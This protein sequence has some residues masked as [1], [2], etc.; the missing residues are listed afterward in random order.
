MTDTIVFDMGQ[1]L[2]RWTPEKMIAQYNLNEQ[3]MHLLNTELF[4]G[5]EWVMQDRGILSEDQ[6]VA[7][8]RARLPETLHEP[9]KTLVYGWH[10]RYLEPMPGMGALVREL[11]ANG[12]RICLLSN[13]GLALR[14]YFDRIPGSECFDGLMVSAEEK[15]LKPQHEIYETLFRKFGLIPENCM[16]IDDAPANVEGGM[17]VGMPGII[18][19]GDV[20]RLRRELAA[21][22]IR[23]SA[24]GEM[25]YDI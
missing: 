22:G 24:D 1:V 21:A 23:C 18:F 25:K 13:A 2:I 7:R 4:K 11:K 8:V 3:E 6:V 9:V 17:L 14:D 16:F 5:V 10:Q 20:P 15:L 19:R 12:Y